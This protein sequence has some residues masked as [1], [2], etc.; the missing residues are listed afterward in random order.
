MWVTLAVIRLEEGALGWWIGEETVPLFHEWNDFADGLRT[1]SRHQRT[2]GRWKYWIRGTNESV[3]DY[4]TRFHK[5]ILADIPPSLSN[6]KL[7]IGFWIH[8][9]R[10]TREAIPRP[11]GPTDLDVLLY[12]A[13]KAARKTKAKK[14]PRICVSDD[15]GTSETRTKKRFVTV[16]YP[17]PTY[18][19]DSEDTTDPVYSPLSEDE[20]E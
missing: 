15:E 18:T 2:L 4:A 5:E 17:E 8:L 6:E 9:P 13:R 11:Y 10:I 1:W 19:P 12:E 14:T 16:P 7:A 20:E 3:K